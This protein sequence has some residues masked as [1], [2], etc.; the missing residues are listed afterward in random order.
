MSERS[1]MISTK[2]LVASALI[3]SVLGGSVLAEEIHEG[4]TRLAFEEYGRNHLSVFAGGTRLEGDNFLSFGVEYEYRVN[5][6]LGVG[7][8]Y[9]HAGGELE[10]DSVLAAVDLHPFGEGLIIQL[11]LGREYSTV[12]GELHHGDQATRSDEGRIESVSVDESVLIGRVGVIYEFELDNLTVAPQVHYDAHA[13][14]SNSI[15]Y[16]VSFGI[17]F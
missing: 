12:T 15:V 5:A 11:G 17:N 13:G 4:G 10:A 3:V 8:L 9:E 1:A 16:G 7:I 14:E 6:F 2:L